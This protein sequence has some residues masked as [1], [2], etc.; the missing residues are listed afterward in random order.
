MDTETLE[1]QTEELEQL[2]EPTRP[3]LNARDRC[4]SCGIASRAYVRI[5]F[6]TGFLDFCGH[7]YNRYEADLIALAKEVIDERYWIVDT[8]SNVGDGDTVTD[9]DPEPVEGQFVEDGTED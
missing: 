3:T 5:I 9:S 1:P 7:H 2:H 4:D 8:Q 6:P